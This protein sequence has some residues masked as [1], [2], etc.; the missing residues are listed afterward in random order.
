[1]DVG[2]THTDAVVMS[3]TNVVS[4][5]KVATTSDVTSGLV[6]ALAGVLRAAEISTSEVSFVVIGTTHFTNAVVERRE[7]TPTAIVRLCLP[8]AQ[9]LRPMA[10][11]PEDLIRVI[12]RHAYLA[13]GG[14]E[15]DGNPIAPFQE[16]EFAAIGDDIN[17]KGLK[18][19]AI[20]GVFSPINAEMEERVARLLA[21]RCPDADITTSASIGGL[22]LLERESAVIL[23]GALLALARRTI[24]GL[25]DGLNSC[26]LGCPFFV[27][28][29]DGTLVCAERVER[30]P[31][32]TFA[33][34][35]TNSMRGA[36]FLSGHQNA[37]VIDVGGTT[38]DVGLLQGGF[39]RQ[40]STTVNV[41]GVRT[42]FR[43]PDVF[44]IGVGGGS[45]VDVDGPSVRIGPKSVGWAIGREARV[46]GGTVLTATDI[47]VASGRTVA[48]DPGLV[49]GLDPLLVGAAQA[50]IDRL[51][52]EAV[53]RARVSAVPLPVIAVGG[54]SVLVPDRMGGVPVVRPP[55]Y[56]V[57]NAVG[58]AIAQISGETDQVF[59]LDSV[60][61]AEA[62]ASA[63]ADARRHAINAGAIPETV[64]I[65][66]REDTPLAYL[67]GNATRIRVKAVGEMRV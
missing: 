42:N 8:A 67:P 35:P 60:S 54:G 43:M 23:N 57:A 34:G 56:A 22:G 40:A 3:G 26:G 55:H 46:F 41:G 51:L 7:L 63:E 1:M 29:N 24:A 28:Q 5:I 64:V 21:L 31:I 14:L 38:S 66:E 47:G 50:E 45:R 18:A 33:S 37:I 48:G 4:A 9:S 61:R 59:S 12:G 6:A 19:I 49:E 65:L 36:A 30:F 58:A 11:W 13:S 10:G 2:G 39:P 32:L 52:E 44:S 62:L 15:F 16:A 20:C 53:D 25:R 27:S 17:R